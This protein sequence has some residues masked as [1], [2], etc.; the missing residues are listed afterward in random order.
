[1]S[2]TLLLLVGTF[3]VA[4]LLFVMAGLALLLIRRAT[5]PDAPPHTE[6]SRR[7]DL[8]RPNAEE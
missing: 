6:V 8:P 4:V 5:T 7:P 2:S 1:M 3:I